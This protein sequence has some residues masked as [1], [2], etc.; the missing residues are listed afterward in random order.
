MHTYSVHVS[1]ERTNT[2]DSIG[3]NT[4]FK[5]PTYILVLTNIRNAHRM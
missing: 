3:N 2:Y 1:R 5:Y 4:V